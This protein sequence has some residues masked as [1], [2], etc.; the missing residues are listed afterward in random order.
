MSF[1]RARFG[2][3]LL[4]DGHDGDLL[5]LWTWIAVFRFFGPVTEFACAGISRAVSVRVH[6]L[7]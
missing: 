3:C 1:S 7:A 4:S 2:Q 6:T 5:G